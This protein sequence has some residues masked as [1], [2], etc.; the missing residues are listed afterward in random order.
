MGRTV[1][2]ILLCAASAICVL[3]GAI[4]AGMVGAAD[5]RLDGALLGF[6][7]L[8]VFIIGPLAAVGVISLVRA[9]QEATET[10]EAE[11][12]RQLLDMVKTR[13][14]LNVSDA[15]IELN[16]DLPRLQK[17]VYRLV[18]LGVFTG[19][20]N[21]DEGVLYSEEASLLRGAEK[22]RHCGG[23]LKLAGKGV[24]KCP[25][26]GTEYF[27]GPATGDSERKG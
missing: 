15:S 17:M 23:D 13:G 8:V 21:W 6:S 18:G 4:L 5:L 14:R 3:G 7:L 1:G 19:Y 9:R 10:A 20:V 16:S 12:L 11:D 27:M 22:C 25:F 24:V 2:V 26:C